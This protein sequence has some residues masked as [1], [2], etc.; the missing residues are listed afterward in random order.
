[1]RYTIETRLKGFSNQY[2]VLKV[3]R[4]ETSLPIVHT[5]KN[6]NYLKRLLK[7]RYQN[8]TKK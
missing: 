4:N 5:S 8:E 6:V 1:M 7:E 3:Y 2:S